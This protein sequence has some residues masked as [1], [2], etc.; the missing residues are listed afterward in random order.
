MK[1]NSIVVTCAKGITPYLKQEIESLGLPV[2]AETTASVMTRGDMDVAMRLNLF[3]RTG[4]RVLLMLKEFTAQNADELYRELFDIRWEEYIPEDSYLC[5]TS[6]VDN[7]TINDSRYANL[8]CKDAVVDRMLHVCG[9]R[10]DSGP[11]RDRCVV[12]LYWKD[13]VCIVYLDTSGEPLSKRGYRKLPVKAPMQETLAAAVIMAT[14]WQGGTDFVNPMCGSGTLAIEAALMAVGKAPGLLRTN[15]GFMHYRGYRAANWEAMRLEAE[16]MVRANPEVSIIASDID[17]DAVDA[18]GKN[19]LAAGVREDI[20]FDVCDFAETDLPG[21][22]GIVLLNPEY[23]ERLGNE[24]TL[25]HTYGAIGD[26]F[27]QRCKGYTGYIFT[28]NTALAKKVG[29]RPKR[30]I[31]F[32]NADIEC[33]LLEYELYE[34]TR[35]A[36][37]CESG[38]NTE[39]R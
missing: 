6:S 36:G 18:A 10:P 28:G 25:Q 29:L 27:K 34:G 37:K 8:K 9:R 5:V 17:P 3:L 12:Y 15:F 32:F 4:H 24:E 39:S 2:V 20:L 21:R 1:N 35:K 11:D 7:R 38:T 31:P 13:S 22:G 16:K 23:G 26:F 33:R 19:A 30:R 14:G